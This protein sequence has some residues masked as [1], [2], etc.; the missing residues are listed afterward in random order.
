MKK[1]RY[2]MKYNRGTLVLVP[3]PFTDLSATKRRPALV[4]SPD[5]FNEKTEDL[6]LVAVTS[7]FPPELSEIEIPLEKADLKEGILPKRSLVR[8]AKI[9]TMHSGLIV[10]KAGSLKDQKIQEILD[11]LIAF[12]T[13]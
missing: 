13:A 10:K 11:R 12:L 8:L 1:M 6:I 3:F 2:G 9:F 4:I 5:R 7:K